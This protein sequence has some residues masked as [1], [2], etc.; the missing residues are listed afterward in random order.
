MNIRE[1]T[2]HVPKIVSSGNIIIV[3]M[4]NNPAVEGTMNPKYQ[5]L[6]TTRGIFVVPIFFKYMT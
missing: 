3:T 2:S 4:T 5:E 1:V 6:F